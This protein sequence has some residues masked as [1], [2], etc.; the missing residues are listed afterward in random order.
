[1]NM[2]IGLLL[3]LSVL[4]TSVFMNSAQAAET[5]VDSVN[6]DAKQVFAGKVVVNNATFRAPIPG[7]DN[8]VGHAS[9]TNN[10]SKDIVL[11]AAQSKVAGKVEFHDHK[12]VN[13]MMKMFQVEK[14]EIP[15]G[16]TITFT[17]GGLHL[18]FFDVELLSND[19]KLIEVTFSTQSGHSFSLPF[20][21][22][23]IKMKHMHH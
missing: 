23:S 7:M 8:S 19:A 12:M 5:A 11:V 13:G 16:E 10:G 14:V 3:S 21:V 18:M 17:T 20:E 22:K 15:A 1:M 4:S 6:S 2:R 9:I